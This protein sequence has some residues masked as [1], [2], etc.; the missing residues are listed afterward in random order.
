MLLFLHL[1]FAPWHRF[2]A[3]LARQDNAGAAAQLAQIRW[4][5]TINLI[6]GLLTVAVGSSGRYWG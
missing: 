1:Y 5:V 6:L 2:R 4:I 3:A